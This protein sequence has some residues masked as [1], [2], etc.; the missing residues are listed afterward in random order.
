V[1]EAA[2]IQIEVSARAYLSTLNPL[3]LR[4]RF[5]E[6]GPLAIREVR[7]YRAAIT[8]IEDFANFVSF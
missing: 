3:R 6:I 1:D 2:K 7:A 4:V 5:F 8:L